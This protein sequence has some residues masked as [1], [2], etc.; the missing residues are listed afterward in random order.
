MLTGFVQQS[1]YR[2][3]NGGRLICAVCDFDFAAFYGSLGEGFMHV[4]H[5]DPISE[6]RSSR[7]VSPEFELVPVCPNCHSMIH[8]RGKNRSIADMR[9]I[10][11][12]T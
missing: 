1:H 10:L 7:I 12:R 9:R 5:L 4:H 6:A 11:V 2:N 8:R 3:K